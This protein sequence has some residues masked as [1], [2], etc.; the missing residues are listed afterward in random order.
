[1]NVRTNLPFYLTYFAYRQTVPD[2]DTSTAQVQTLNDGCG[3]QGT[4]RAPGFR[5]CFFDPHKH[6]C[7]PQPAI[8]GC[9]SYFG[10]VEPTCNF[11]HVFDGCL[12]R[13][14]YPFRGWLNPNITDIADRLI[15]PSPIS[16]TQFMVVMVVFLLPYA[17]CWSC[18]L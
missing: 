8:S 16:P 4:E 6:L 17:F 3:D 18:I 13:S 10:G 7:Y 11:N 15:F 12:L 1:L 9:L 2:T 5:P 14:N